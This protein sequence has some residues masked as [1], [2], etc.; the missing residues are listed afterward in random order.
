[1][2]AVMK[3]AFLMGKAPADFA[4]MASKMYPVVVSTP[5]IRPFGLTAHQFVFALAAFEMVAAL[6]FFY[7]HKIASMMVVAVMAGAEYMAF[8]QGSNP[9][10]P[11]SP[12]CVGEAACRASHIFHAVLVLLA[13]MS[14][15]C[16]KPV[17]SAWSSVCSKWGWCSSK[18]GAE[19]A[20]TPS[21]PRRA[22]AMKKK[23]N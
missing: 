11:P 18:K 2:A 14:Y 9:A 8:T 1:M 6:A 5:L 22:A 19:A 16:E 13:V 4:A 10:M 20:Q 3:F 21:R 7:N 17:C 12:V 23:D 15:M